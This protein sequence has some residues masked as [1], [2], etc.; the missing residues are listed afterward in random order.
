MSWVKEH[1]ADL[2]ESKQRAPP[3]EKEIFE[4]MLI[5]RQLLTSHQAAQEIYH[6]SLAP[7]AVDL[8]SYQPGDCLAIYPQNQTKHVAQILDALIA[9]DAQEPILEG[10]SGQHLPLGEYLLKRANLTI[11][12]AS[13]AIALAR[14]LKSC[15]VSSEFFKKLCL[16]PAQRSALLQFCRA[17]TVPQLLSRY[18]QLLTAQQLADHLQPLLPRL[19]SIASASK[20]T[21]PSVDLT[22]SYVQ[23]EGKWPR[24]GVCSHWLCRDLKLGQHLN[25]HFHPHNDFHPPSDPNRSIIMIGAGTGIAPFRGF[26]QQRAFNRSPGRNWLIMGQ[27]QRQKDFLYQDFLRVLELAGLLRLDLAFSRDQVEKYYVSH[28]MQRCCEDIAKELRGEAVIYVCG[29]IALGKSV[30]QALLSILQ[31]QLSLDALQA[32]RFL[33]TLRKEGRY[34]RDVY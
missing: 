30:H 6:I 9:T 12:S 2:M 3:G 26:L 1:A 23:T 5:S 8:S 21:D 11:C 29:S 27:R 20:W 33:R 15:D 7:S 25:A 14:A 24:Q 17:R 31:E 32:E 18:R 4:M 10:R 22:V 19:Y 16:D 28:A 13:L 34:K